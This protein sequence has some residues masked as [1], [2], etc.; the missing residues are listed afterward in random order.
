MYLVYKL[1]DFVTPDCTPE[2]FGRRVVILL[3]SLDSM[4]L[5]LIF[6]ACSVFT[7]AIWI[8]RELIPFTQKLLH[9]FDQFI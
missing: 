4:H 5:I 3:W 8:M 6:C 7:A 1:F 9:N 2:T